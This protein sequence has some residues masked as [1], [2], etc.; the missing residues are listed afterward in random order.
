MTRR[1]QSDPGEG[2]VS[3]CGQLAE[4]CHGEERAAGRAECLEGAF[5]AGAGSFA[6]V[7]AA[8]VECRFHAQ[9]P[10]S[11]GSGARRSR[12]LYTPES[13]NQCFFAQR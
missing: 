1:N 3:A 10:G 5:P 8:A 9:G 7:G 13:E 4:V 12:V 11:A 6:Q 2:G